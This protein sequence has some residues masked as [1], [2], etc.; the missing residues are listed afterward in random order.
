MARNASRASRAADSASAHFW[1]TPRLLARTCNSRALSN[2]CASFR[3]LAALPASR[4]SCSSAEESGNPLPCGAFIVVDWEGS[5]RSAQTNYFCL[6]SPPASRAST[7]DHVCSSSTDSGTK[8]KHRGH[9]AWPA[10]GADGDEPVGVEVESG[11][12]SVPSICLIT[13][14]SE[15]VS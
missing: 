13:P 6:P 3:L 15:F 14:C 1:D 7:Q 12:P 8:V 5:F 10:C 2:N 4:R 11:P 9:C